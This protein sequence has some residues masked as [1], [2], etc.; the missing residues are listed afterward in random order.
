MLPLISATEEESMSIM[1]PSSIQVIR[2]I[3]RGNWV[4]SIFLFFT[5][6]NVTIRI[7]NKFQ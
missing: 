3:Y 7:K 4:V 2:E 6:F 5:N 1:T